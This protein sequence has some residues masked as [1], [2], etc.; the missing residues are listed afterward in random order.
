MALVTLG[1]NH[2][3]APVELRERVAFTPERMAEAFAELRATSGA[4]EAAILST[5]NRTEL[6]LAGDDDCAPIPPVNLGIQSG[7]YRY[8][9]EGLFSGKEGSRAQFLIND[10][11]G[12][13]YGLTQ[14]KPGDRVLIDAAGGGG[15]GHPLERD[16]Q[17]V[18]TDVQEGYVTLQGAK[19]DYGVVIDPETLQ[20][21]LQA[22]RREREALGAAD[23]YPFD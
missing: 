5:C 12:N 2:R 22:T 19:E 14:L 15:C 18:E 8:P 13:P 6:Y 11:P 17:R 23:G 16:P 20:V 3:T 9:P 4:T 21:D 7:R 1:I 10:Q